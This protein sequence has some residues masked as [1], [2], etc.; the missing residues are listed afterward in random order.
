VVLL[1]ALGIAFDLG[2]AFIVKNEAQAFTDSAALSATIRLNGTAAGITAAK[3]AVTADANKWMM[4]TKTFTSVT[5]EFSAD[6]AT[7]AAN[8]ANPANMRFV[9]VKAPNNSI[10]IKFLQ[11]AGS[12]ETMSPTALSVA[13]YQLPTTFP[14]GVF[15]FAP[16]AHSPTP[17]DFGYVP[18]DELTLLWPS[19]VGSNGQNVKLTN[20]CLA[21]RNQAALDA[22]KEGINSER[23]YI[24]ETAAS[25]IAS[26]I[27][28]DHM[29]YTISLGQPVVRTGGIKNTDVVQSLADRV[30]QDS[31]P[32]EPN[33]AT[34]VANHDSSPMRRIVVVPI[35]DGA[36][37]AIA[38]GFVKVFLPP[39]QP[40][41]PNDS[42]CA[43]YIGPADAPSGNLGS[44]L[45]AVRLFQ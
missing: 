32:S 3:A 15:P 36:V 16:I 10:T 35:I 14:Q 26:A 45:N 2:R 17:P 30:A 33:Y 9:R 24:M 13:G 25:S 41:N 27:E 7:W 43:M 20:L 6:K 12:T 34:Y 5:T 18:G 38:V 44:G 19:S 21:D 8:P 11:A 31:M 42:R 4:N 40:G 37:S 28:D 1:G 23:G 29:D 39:S 22:V